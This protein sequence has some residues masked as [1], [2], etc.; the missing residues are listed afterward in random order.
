[1]MLSVTVKT[2]KPAAID[3]HARPGRQPEQ[4][5]TSTTRAIR[6]T[7]ATGYERFVATAIGEPPTDPSTA[8]KTIAVETAATAVPPISPSSHMLLR[9][10]AIRARMSR[11]SPA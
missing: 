10:S 11:T 9:N 1:Y 8:S 6:T 5:S 3:A 4:V 2:A 7:S